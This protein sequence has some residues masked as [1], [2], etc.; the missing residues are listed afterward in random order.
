MSNTKMDKILN[1]DIKLDL[2]SYRSERISVCVFG[3]HSF[4]G[5]QSKPARQAL[6]ALS[7]SNTVIHMHECKTKTRHT[8]KSKQSGFQT[9]I[10]IHVY[11]SRESN[12][13]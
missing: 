13:C 5:T 1:D 9:L 12:A 3:T 11:G 6:L 8:K 10:Y 4:A 7:F 2:L